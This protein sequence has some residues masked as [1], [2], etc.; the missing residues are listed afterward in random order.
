MKLYNGDCLD[1]MKT[2]PSESY[3]ACMFPYA[4]SGGTRNF[5]ENKTIN[6][7][8]FKLSSKNI[9]PYGEVESYGGSAT[10]YFKNCKLDEHDYDQLLYIAK[11]S[12]KER[13]QGLDGFEEKGIKSTNTFKSAEW[14]IDPR[15]PNGGYKVKHDTKHRNVHP[16]VKPISLINYLVKLVKQPE[17]NLIIDPFMGSGTTGIACKKEG[18]N[19]T[20][21]EMESEYFEIAKARIEN[22]TDKSTPK[23]AN[24]EQTEVTPDKIFSVEKKSHKNQLELF[25]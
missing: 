17:N 11:A 13:N 16:A 8:S 14:N 6:S 9:I 24:V 23:S 3:T 5:G 19:F 1:V 22:Y 10:R 4:K 18:I 7:H 12:S 20:G 2:L 25:G 21:I 15:S